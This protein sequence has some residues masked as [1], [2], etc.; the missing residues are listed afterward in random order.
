[1]RTQLAEDI[2]TGGGRDVIYTYD[3]LNRVL[4]ESA[5]AASGSYYAEYTYD[6]VG[7]RVKRIISANGQCMQTDYEYNDQ[8]QLVKVSACKYER[9]KSKFPVH[10]RDLF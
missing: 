3:N 2:S 6:I 4:T 7:N 10:E 8:D 9:C 5:S 1:M